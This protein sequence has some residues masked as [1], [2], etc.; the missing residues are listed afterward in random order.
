MSASLAPIKHTIG[1]TL[2]RSDVLSQ[3]VR[4]IRNEVDYDSALAAI[5]LLGDPD[6]GT[7]EGDRFEVLVTLVEA[8]DREHYPIPPPDPISM[9]EY[10]IESRGLTRRDLEPYIG[11]RARVSEVLNKKRALSKEMIRKLHEGL[12]LELEILVQPYELNH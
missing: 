6:P 4:P 9:I 3:P 7:P 10:Y 5:D 11:T 2:K 1:S 12:G 8:Y